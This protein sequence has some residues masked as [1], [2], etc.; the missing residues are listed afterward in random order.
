ML[1]INLFYAADMPP[2]LEGR[3]EPRVENFFRLPGLRETLAQGKDVRVVM[4]P[5]HLG[6]LDASAKRGANPG[7]PVGRDAHAYSRAANEHRALA[8]TA[9]QR[10]CGSRGV[11]GI[12]DR[13]RRVGAAVNRFVRKTA[14]DFFEMLLKGKT[15]VVGGNSNFHRE[16]YHRG[17]NDVK[18][19][20][21]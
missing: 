20:R 15:G 11:V 10:P 14:Q 12:I 4:A 5:G 18:A 9:R 3:V 21:R 13:L 8:L 16:G 2:P 6:V 17:G 7:K 19:V 1:R